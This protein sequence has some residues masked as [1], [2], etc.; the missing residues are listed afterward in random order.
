MNDWLVLPLVSPF[1]VSSFLA[2]G[3]RSNHAIRYCQ[4][5]SGSSTDMEGQ[6]WEDWRDMKS[7]ELGTDPPWGVPLCIDVLPSGEAV[8][9]FFFGERGLIVH[10][11]ATG[12]KLSLNLSPKPFDASVAI[13]ESSLTLSLATLRVNEG[14]PDG[15]MQLHQVSLRYSCHESESRPQFLHEPANGCGR[16]CYE[17]LA[18]QQSPA[19][20]PGSR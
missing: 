9:T 3:C 5:D 18:R 17:E 10:G 16:C 19:L 13:H 15:P 11:R 2:S 7:H 6:F 8:G 20:A 4:F 14:A 12:N 1:L